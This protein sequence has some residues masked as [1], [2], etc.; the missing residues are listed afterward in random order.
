MEENKTSSTGSE[1]PQPGPL[2]PQHF[3]RYFDDLDT[4]RAHHELKIGTLKQKIIKTGQKNHRLI[5]KSVKKTNERIYRLEKEIRVLREKIKE[6]QKELIQHQRKGISNQQEQLPGPTLRTAPEIA[7]KEGFS[8]KKNSS[9]NRNF[10]RVLKEFFRKNKP[11]EDTTT[12]S[13]IANLHNF[14]EKQTKQIRS[15][16][17]RLEE[18]SKKKPS[19]KRRTGR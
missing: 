6:L 19:Q 17:T 3:R 15:E 12:S 8:F 11:V 1:L 14:V 10:W 4:E 18:T 7:S 13:V 9:N 2:K 5:K 16:E